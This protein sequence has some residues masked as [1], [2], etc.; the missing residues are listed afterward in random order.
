M[1]FLADSGRARRAAWFFVCLTL[2]VA[3]AA[4]Q[5]PGV[6]TGSVL[7]E[8][9]AVL[10][11]VSIDLNTAAGIRSTTS[12][13]TGVYRFDDVGAGP[14]TLTFRL[15]NFSTLRRDLEVAA[16]E[17]LADAVLTLG[18]TADVVVTGRRTFRNI[19]DMDNPS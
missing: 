5:D 4:A 11:G 9:G 18:L 3:P 13:G 10:P 7:D 19:A 15:V 14:A 1:R 12:D 6:V 8:T 2:A 17:N 16:G